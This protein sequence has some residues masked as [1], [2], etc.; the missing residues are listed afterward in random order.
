MLL[1]VEGRKVAG[2][3]VAHRTVISAD[4]NVILCVGDGAAPATIEPPHGGPLV[5][6]AARCDTRVTWGSPEEG[7]TCRQL[8]LASGTQP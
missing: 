4:R 5:P 1:G 3:S 2:A 6:H 8:G 7:Q